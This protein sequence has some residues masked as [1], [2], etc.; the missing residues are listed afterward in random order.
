MSDQTVS[1]LSL[2][3]SNEVIELVDAN[4]LARDALGRAHSHA[5]P[6]PRNRPRV[7][8]ANARLRK[9]EF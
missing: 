2:A 6:R 4:G 7:K 9:Y 5:N 3:L 1:T 8:N